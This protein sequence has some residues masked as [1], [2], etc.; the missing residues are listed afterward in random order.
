MCLTTGDYGMRLIDNFTTSAANTG[1]FCL[2]LNYPH[3]YIP[4]IDVSTPRTL[5]M[6]VQFGSLPVIKDGACLQ[7]FGW[8]S[9]GANFA[10]T[11]CSFDFTWG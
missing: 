3:A 5:Q 10:N 6:V 2:V 4:V 1:T 11:P 7:F 8:T 9:G